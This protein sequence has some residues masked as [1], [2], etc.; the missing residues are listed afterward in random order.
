MKATI[1]GIYAI[2]N[3]VNGHKYIGSAKNIAKRQIEHFNLLKN[4]KHYN[5]HLQSAYLRYGGENFEYL[6]IE[7][8]ECSKE[9]LLKREQ[10]YIDTLNPEYNLS[11]SAQNCLGVKHSEQARKNMTIAARNRGATSIETRIKMSEAH[12]GNQAALGYRHT[13][14]AKKKVSKSLIGNKRRLG[15]LHTLETKVKMTGPRGPLGR[16]KKPSPPVSDETRA[17]LSEAKR[18]YW[19]NQNQESRNRLSK[20]RL[21]IIQELKASSDDK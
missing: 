3:K 5:R 10:Y 20:A 11:P 4:N 12:K 9:I 16:K 18:L 15:I 6:I 17:K 19:S 1:S 14:E 7:Q 2:T 8:C 21:K 13:E